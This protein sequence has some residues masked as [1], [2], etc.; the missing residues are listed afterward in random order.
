MTTR[1]LL[2][3][4]G[5]V[6]SFDGARHSMDWFHE[7]PGEGGKY[8]EHMRA[9]ICA[10]GI[11]Q[12]VDDVPGSV[13][14][15]TLVASDRETPNSFDIRSG[16]TLVNVTSNLDIDFVRWLRKSYRRGCRFVQLEIGK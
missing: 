3:E 7:V 14:Y 4:R 13:R 6:S 12:Y 15:I 11:R 5:C 1:E 10:S 9:E 2:L 16:G 8:H